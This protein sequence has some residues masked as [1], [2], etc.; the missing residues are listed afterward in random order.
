LRTNRHSVGMMV[1]SDHA[2][3]SGIGRRGTHLIILCARE[4]MCSGS[5]VE[6]RRRL[7]TSMAT[8]WRWPL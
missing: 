7:L 3:E 6:G 4:A 1:A 2:K 5:S 8:L